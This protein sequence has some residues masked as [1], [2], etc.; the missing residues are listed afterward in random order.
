[1]NSSKIERKRL[2]QAAIKWPLYSVAVMPLLLAAG[3]K[4][5]KGE[6]FQIAQ[7]IVFLIASILI[8]F[9]E[10]LTNDLFDNET[11]VDQ[12]K[13]HSVVA[14]V[15][16][17]AP[18]SKIA[19]LSLALGLLLTLILAINSNLIVLPLILVCC[20]LGYVLINL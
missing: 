3:W 20:F 5:G 2:W 17:K 9:W 19:Y 7:F 6:G 12:F 18:V 15:C 4:I 14:L 13:L 11:G 10:N 8:L 16:K 1:M